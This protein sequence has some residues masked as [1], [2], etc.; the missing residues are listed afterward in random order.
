MPTL[1]RNK[2]RGVQTGGFISHIAMIAADIL[3][4]GAAVGLV[5]ASGHGRPLVGGDLFAGFTI[6]IEDNS[7]GLAAALNAEVYKLGIIELPVSGAVITDLGQPVYAT[8]DDT[9]TFNPVGASYIGNVIRF[10][11][12]GVVEVEFNAGV[13]QDPYGD[14]VKE[15]ISINKTL[16]V[17]DTGK[18]FFVDTDATTTTLPATVTA[19]SCRLVNIGAFGTVAVNASPV[20][21]DKIMGPDIAGAND[22]DLINTKAT[23]QRG[24]FVDIRGG[25]ADGFVVD[26]M[27]GTW[28]EEA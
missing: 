25:H 28:A 17:E 27:R 7:L 15:T 21:A 4:G 13:L 3:Y 14:G 9:F 11:S 2:S 22:K 18:T 10:V 19:I 6:D 26:A 8:D 1:S 5:E 23:A 16:D 20:V 24:D 12:A